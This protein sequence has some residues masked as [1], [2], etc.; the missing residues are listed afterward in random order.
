M[1]CFNQFNSMITETLTF[2]GFTYISK[3]VQIVSSFSH[4]IVSWNMNVLQVFV[5]VYFDFFCKGCPSL[6]YAKVILLQIPILRYFLLW[7]L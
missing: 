7:N 2:H 1:C 4:I 5:L 6:G 3:V